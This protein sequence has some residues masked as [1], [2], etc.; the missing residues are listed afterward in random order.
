MAMP[1]VTPGP[2][3]TAE[4]FGIDDWPASPAPAMPADS[5]APV[6]APVGEP[7]YRY[8]KPNYTHDEEGK[9]YMGWHWDE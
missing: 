6:V 9:P 5:D 7:R 3:T 8:G 4:D 2:P 1:S